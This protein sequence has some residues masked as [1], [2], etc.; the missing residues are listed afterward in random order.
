MLFRSGLAADVV[1]IM[2]PAA[3][4]IGEL[5]LEGGDDDGLG[6]G[7]EG[8]AFWCSLNSALMEGDCV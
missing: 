1:V 5:C 2:I 4:E 8:R 7:I 6:N 3:K